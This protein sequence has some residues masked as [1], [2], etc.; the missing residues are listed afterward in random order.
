MK[1][2]KLKF[3]YKIEDNIVML[4]SPGGKKYYLGMIYEE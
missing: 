3:R 2:S 1:I 4:I